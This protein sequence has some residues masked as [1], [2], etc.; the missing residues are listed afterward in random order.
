MASAGTRQQI[1]QGPS[2]FLELRSARLNTSRLQ[3][4][5]RSKSSLGCSG[6]IDHMGVPAR[7]SGSPR[8]SKGMP[9]QPQRHWRCPAGMIPQWGPCRS[10]ARHRKTVPS[11]PEGDIIVLP[12]STLGFGLRFCDD[13]AGLVVGSTIESWSSPI[14]Q[15]LGLPE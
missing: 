8:R 2:R 14:Q 3:N 9:R 15:N 7:S 13:G 1:G 5:V 6:R 4:P 11:P 10:R 12:G